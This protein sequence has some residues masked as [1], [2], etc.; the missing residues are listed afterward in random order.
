MPMDVSIGS[1][2]RDK[3]MPVYVPREAKEMGINLIPS[4]V[5]AKGTILGRI[6]DT[7]DD[8]QTMTISGTPTGGTYTI[9]LEFPSG[10][11]QTTTALAYNANAATIQAALQALSNIGSG[12]VA[13]TGT[14]PYVATFGGNLADKPVPLMTTTGSFTGGSS[15]AA[16][17]VHTTTG[18]TAGTYKAY[19]TGASDGSETAV[20]ILPYAVATDG[21]GM[22]TLGTAAT[23][24]E[25]GERELYVDAYFSGWFKTSELVGLDA[26]G[27]ADLNASVKSGTLADGIIYIPG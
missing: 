14:G 25:Y 4:T 11:S 5:F 19:A 24:G 6:T 21:A 7:A 1:Y 2:T 20:C 3:L 16:T 26:A 15:P 23:G 12:N 9:T 27:L 22:I 10:N 18:R 13:V 17:F 8:V